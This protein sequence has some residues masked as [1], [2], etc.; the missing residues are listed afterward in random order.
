MTEPSIQA[1]RERK[2]ATPVQREVPTRRR[3]EDHAIIGNLRSAALVAKDGTIDWLCLPDFDSD[4]CFASLVGTP[5]N[6]EWAI[7]PK[8]PARKVERRYRKDTLILET[9]FTCDSGAIR[10]IDF[11]P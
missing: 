8:E 6:G 10:L 3:I 4:A 11:M 1:Q 7:A 5:A 2:P 9:D